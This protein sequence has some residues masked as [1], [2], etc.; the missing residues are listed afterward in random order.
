MS[1]RPINGR[2]PLPSSNYQANKYSGGYASSSTVGRQG[3]LIAVLKGLLGD[4]AIT[5]DA[6][7]TIKNGR[8]SGLPADTYSLSRILSNEANLLSRTIRERILTDNDPISLVF[9][10]QITDQHNFQLNR[11]YAVG[12]EVSLVPERT[13]GLT[14]GLEPDRRAVNLQRYGVNSE[15]H[16]G[17]FFTPD[18]ARENI[19]LKLDRVKNG[20]TRQLDAIRYQMLYENARDVTALMVNANPAMA[21]ADGSTR[22]RHMDTLYSDIM[23]DACSKFENPLEALL[24][25]AGRS[26]NVLNGE[27]RNMLM[28]LPMGSLDTSQVTDPVTER[29]S[30]IDVGLPQNITVDY[31]SI[32]QHPTTGVKVALA[33]PPVDLSNGT[34]YPVAGAGGLSQKVNVAEYYDLSTAANGTYRILNF[35]NNT[36]EQFEIKTGTSGKE[37]RLYVRP[38]I[39]TMMSSGYLCEIGGAAGN[40][41][42][43]HPS[44]DIVKARDVETVKFQYRSWMGGMVYD[45][46]KLLRFPDIYMHGIGQGGGGLDA[47]LKAIDTTV[48]LQQDVNGGKYSPNIKKIRDAIGNKQPINMLDLE[49]TGEFTSTGGGT[50]KNSDVIL[51]LADKFTGDQNAYPT[52]GNSGATDYPPIIKPG[53]VQKLSGN[54]T[55]ETYQEPQGNLSHKRCPDDIRYCGFGKLRSSASLRVNVV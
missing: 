49:Q 51:K 55:W 16:T 37:P 11:K 38:K 35:Q 43:A 50:S 47:G 2:V 1:M 42:V 48:V 40:A 25:A 4:K 19:E 10:T 34:P 3:D 18:L 12:G 45:E 26:Y 36:W 30:K 46:S 20:F 41:F 29:F 39:E 23:Y 15:E 31:S 28:I 54:G 14:V 21:D 32:R 44:A 9:P 6:A 52:E 7:E 33:M 5:V 53:L 24:T 17:I 13:Q 8:Q 27:L 22:M